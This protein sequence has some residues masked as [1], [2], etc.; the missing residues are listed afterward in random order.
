MP[1]EAEGLEPDGRAGGTV[2]S[3]LLDRVP[4][5]TTKTGIN[6]CF[7]VL[8]VQHDH[9]SVSMSALCLLL[10]VSFYSTFPKTVESQSL[11]SGSS[12]DHDQVWTGSELLIPGGGR[13][14]PLRSHVGP[15]SFWRVQPPA[16]VH[17][18]APLPVP[19]PCVAPGTGATAPLWFGQMRKSL[20]GK[21]MYELVVHQLLGKNRLGM[22]GH[23]AKLISFSLLSGGFQGS[24]M[25]T[26]SVHRAAGTLLAH[27]L[28][29]PRKNYFCVIKDK[30]LS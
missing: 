6:V 26:G 7:P 23:V 30:N 28:L 17:A 19:A 15:K 25:R 11:E 10:L 29:Y 21:L 20:W 3:A 5:T 24:S 16:E 12:T 8:A 14:G 2:A 4:S 9:P 22:C 27:K 18:L 13:G 1:G